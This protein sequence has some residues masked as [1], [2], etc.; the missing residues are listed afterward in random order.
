MLVK[1]IEIMFKRSEEISREIWKKLKNGV[2][3]HC[4]RIESKN[5]RRYYCKKNPECQGDECCT[6]DDLKR[7]PLKTSPKYDVL[8][9]RDDRFT[10]VFFNVPTTRGEQDIVFWIEADR[11]HP[12]MFSCSLQSL[13]YKDVESSLYAAFEEA[14][15][16]HWK[17]FIETSNKIETAF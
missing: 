17:H 4:E 13:D 16:R 2:C 9:N 5:V 1:P 11:L 10:V 15:R 8:E 3:P 6:F 12:R 7:C 14:I